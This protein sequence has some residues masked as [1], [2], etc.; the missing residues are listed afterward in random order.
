MGLICSLISNTTPIR[1]EEAEGRPTHTMP[2]LPSTGGSGTISPKGADKVMSS[3]ADSSR[4]RTNLIHC[5]EGNR[6]IVANK[7][8]GG[9]LPM[10]QKKQAPAASGGGAKVETG[11]RSPVGL[12]WAISILPVM[13]RASSAKLGV[14]RLCVTTTKIKSTRDWRDSRS[15]TP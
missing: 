1:E 3:A 6:S 14:A 7:R 13:L 4:P 10:E 5:G 2:W 9:T 15:K 8:S 11:N 12:A